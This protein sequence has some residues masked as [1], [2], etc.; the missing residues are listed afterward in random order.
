[1]LGLTIPLWGVPLPIGI[2]F[3]TFQ[4]MSYTIDV[5]RKDAPVQRSMVDFGTFVTM[6]PQLIAGP[7][8]Q[9]KTVAA[10]LAHRAN[11][12]E[13]FALGARRFCVALPRRSCWPTPSARCG[14]MSG[15]SGG[16]DVDCPG[17]L[18]GSRRLRLPDLL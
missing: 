17:R 8:V 3:Y 4:T 13:N 18:A 14:R 15:G 11:T 1:M 10:E 16:G 12:S 7:I 9:Y 2:S 5:Y 6:F